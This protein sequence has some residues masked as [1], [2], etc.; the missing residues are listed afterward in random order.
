M[1]DRACSELQ[2]KINRTIPLS[3]AMGY[4]ITE[5]D[6]CHITVSAPLAP[7][8]N[9]HGTGF[10]GSLYALGILTAWG[11]CAHLIEHAGIDAN[12]VVAQA[13]IRYRLPIQADIL[14]RSEITDAEAAA[15]IEGL[16]AKGRSRIVVGVAIGDGPAA[17]IEATM[18]ASLKNQQ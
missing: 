17:S 2:A 13:N 5:L 9:I 12:L 8:I 6:T 4:R 14:C 3:E 16:T 15:F 1:N 11:L 10:A 18:H 7:N